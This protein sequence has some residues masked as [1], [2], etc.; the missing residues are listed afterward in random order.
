MVSCPPLQYCLL[1][2]PPVRHPDLPPG[3]FSLQEKDIFKKYSVVLTLW[4]PDPPPCYCSP[5]G[6]G[7][8]REVLQ[9]APG[10]AA[11]GGTIHFGRRR[12]RDDR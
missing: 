7:R 1:T 5:I 3:L 12:A 6:E 2:P 8:L 11:A 10:Q 4:H 9:A